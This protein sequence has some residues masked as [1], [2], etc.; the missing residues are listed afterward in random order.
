MFKRIF[1]VGLSAIAIVMPPLFAETVDQIDENLYATEK[2]TILI[3]LNEDLAV[4]I[5]S[6]MHLSGQLEIYTDTISQGYLIYRKVMKTP[7]RSQAEDFAEQIFVDIVGGPQGVNINLQ[8]PNPAPWT[9][10]DNAGRIQGEL[11]LPRN[12]QIR[13]AA[14]YFDVSAVGPFRKFIS[15]PS[16][17]VMK[18]KKVTELLE[19][20]GKGRK[21]ILDEIGGM[22]TVRAENTTVRIND[23][24]TSGKPA[25]IRNEN[26]GIVIKRAKG[27][28]DIRCEYGKV[29]I[30]DFTVTGP[31]NS[32]ACV[33]CP[34]KVE[35]TEVASDAEL[36]INNTHEDVELQMPPDP[37]TRLVLEVESGGEMHIRDIEVFPRHISDE[38]L[39]VVTGSG[40]ALINVNIEGGGNINIEGESD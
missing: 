36:T 15:E 38:R 16:Y 37:N 28:L 26:G 19:V 4:N 32:I 9:G 13:L 25:I 14:D 22:I 17:G 5:N 23:M 1:I 40:E 18:V 29:R 39:E 12:C 3:N 10:T 6:A 30:S 31:A 2:D 20:H 11:Y 21:V 34:I 35:M 27:A 8:A 33:H 7:D 24:T